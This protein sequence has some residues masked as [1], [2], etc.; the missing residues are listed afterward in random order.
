MARS[1]KI[2]IRRTAAY[3]GMTARFKRHPG[4]DPGSCKGAMISRIPLAR[5]P[6]CAGLTYRNDDGNYPGSAVVAFGMTRV[7]AM[8]PLF[9]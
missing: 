7:V 9:L 6:A 5:P 3:A 4:L 1:Y 2:P 8:M